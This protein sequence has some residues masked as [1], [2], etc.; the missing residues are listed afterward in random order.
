MNKK[1][2][3][4]L[5]S[6]AMTLS[7]AG[8][9]PAGAAASQ[10]T[11]AVK[12]AP[13]LKE[14]YEAEDAEL[15]GVKTGDTLDDF[16][17]SGYAAN[18]GAG[19]SVAFTV[20][21]PVAAKYGVK[22]RYSNGTGETQMVNL[23]VNG[24]KLRT[25]SLAA[26]IN[27]NTWAYR[28]EDVELKAGENTLTYQ[29]D[30]DNTGGVS[31]D[32]I[33]LSWL[34]EAEDAEQLGGMGNNDDH[35]GFTGTGFAAGYNDNGQGRR[36]KV[37][38][39]AAGEYALVM[40][41][42]AGQEN[43]EC[44][45]VSLVINGQKTQVK[46]NSLRSWKIWWDHVST[47]NLNQG[48]NTIEIVRQDGDNGQ[49]NLDY[50][51]VKPVQWTYAGKVEK[52]TG[53]NTSQLTF[54]LDNAAMQVTSVAKNVVK[55]W[56]EPDSRFSRKYES[57][58][59]QSD[60]LDPQ[61]LKA[62]DKNSYYEIDLGDMVMRVQKDPC[63]IT[64]L[65][66]KGNVLME[67]ENESMG[68]TTDGELMVNNKMQDNEAFW[69]LGEKPENNFNR[70]G[71][72]VYMWSVD[73]WGAELDDSF[74]SW[75]EGRYYMATPY[76][77]S[78]K[79][80]SILFDNSS[81]TVFDMGKTDPSTVSFG[82]VNPN[83]GGELCYYF[84]YGGT[85]D[86]YQKQIVKTYTDLIGKSFFAPLWST[87]NIQCH[88]GYTQSDVE[89]VAQTYRDEQIPLDA[90]MVDI[91]WYKYLCTPTAWNNSN[92]PNPE[93][94]LQKMKELNLHF[95][96]IDDPNITKQD[97]NADFVAGDQNGYFVKD[98]TGQ[99]KLINWP[100]GGASGLLDFFNPDARDWWGELHN[101]IL[102][103]G[104][105]FFWLDMNEP[106][107]YNADWLF[108]NEDGKSYG[109]MSEVKNAL[110]LFHHM[111]LYE[112]VTEN[113]QRTLM[114]ARTAYPG[115][116]Q[117][118]SPWTGDIQGSWTSMHQ[119][120]NNGIS[121]SASGYNYWGFDISGFFS[122]VTDEQYKR[123]IELA[124]FTPIHRIHYMTGGP[125]EAYT[126]NATEVS[127]KYIG[128][129]YSLM[130]Y[131]YSLTADNIIGIGIEE[132][133]GT[134]GTGVPITR[135]VATNYPFDENTWNLDTQFMS[136]NSFLVAPMLES[137]TQREVYLP[138]G[139]WYDYDDGKTIY[140]GGQSMSYNAP[141]DLLPVF[142]KEGSIIPMQPVMQYV[143]EKPVDEITLDVFPTLSDGDFHFVLYEDDGETMDYKTGEYTT[144]RYDANVKYT[145]DKRTVTLNIG[146]RTGSY[147]DIDER[148]YMVQLHDGYV[149]NASVTLDGKA[150]SVRSSKE[151]LDGADDGYYMD[152]A[153]RVC[154]VKVKD[155]AKAAS[156]VIS[157]QPIS[158]DTYEAEDGA[159]FGGAKVE[160]TVAGFTGSGYVTGLEADGDG[161]TVGSLLAGQTGRYDLTIRYAN[162]GSRDLTAHVSAN[163]G[164]T[165]QVSFPPTGSDWGEVVVSLHLNAGKNDVTVEVMGRDSGGML[166]DS[167]E[168]GAFPTWLDDMEKTVSQAE[169]GKLTGSAQ[170]ASSADGFT[171][172]GYVQNLTAKGD[173]VVF[174]HVNAPM[175]G[176]YTVYLRYAATDGH[177][178]KTV[179]VYVGDDASKAVQVT[180]P[181]FHNNSW[182]NEFGVTLPLAAG[183]NTVT[184]T[185]GD[186]DSGDILLDSISFKNQPRT[187]T[188]IDI[189]NGGFED[190]DL[191][192][193]TYDNGGAA[194]GGGVDGYDAVR[195]GH[196]FYFFYG[197]GP[198]NQRIGQTVTGLEN[199]TYRLE[200]WSKHYETPFTSLQVEL[201]GY[202]GDEATNLAIP[203]NG[204]WTKYSV[205]CVV[206][207]RQ[208]TFTFHGDSPK[209]S[210]MQLDEV[211]LFKVEEQAISKA[212]LQ[213]LADTA[214]A[215]Q[216][217]DYTA[218]SWQMLA[219]HKANAAQ[220]LAESTPDAQ[221][222]SEGLWRLHYAMTRLE[223]KGGEI[224]D[225]VPGDMDGNGEV[226]IQDVMEACKVLA[227]QSAGKA[228]TEEEML[229]GDLD[230]DD[231]FT[232]TD[233]MEICKI[234][235]R[236]A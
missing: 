203:Y 39:P 142:V 107:K 212:D 44:R 57:F 189:P 111:G 185:V 13:I 216:Q 215:L 89:T 48:E 214:D 197:A 202:N 82:S 94:M 193:W 179:H 234:L 58:S 40:R 225:V 109:N 95:G 158:R 153:K 8:V 213:R 20:E 74:P 187:V 49:F 209:G 72:K 131:T 211:H 183:D 192:G 69:G 76:Y 23:Y 191:T 133:L 87:G 122:D 177:A 92:F 93:A 24:Q 160:S 218:E 30:G 143:G 174:E 75:E 46:L 84:I 208:L 11:D 190:G 168:P 124:S 148:D 16:Y 204:K 126:H 106:A 52:V 171:G 136:G 102:D 108:W 110:A 77:V 37:N 123:W 173:S 21:A 188:E 145:G 125:K 210:S 47:V 6:A 98:Q 137:G 91:E 222:L 59:V 33:A 10:K 64:Y 140:T 32:R 236:K 7:A 85:E 83:P 230:G 170:R 200:F 138:A 228:P 227:R 161:V 199:G 231:K 196:K 15:T 205:E 51:T 36:F 163:A 182:W 120:I 135:S 114:L 70:R 172:S 86:N 233:V 181:G 201:T 66:K 118:V 104:I 229:R 68:W 165:Q 53:D 22:L 61:T 235:A 132:G 3:S 28:T 1:W 232:I 14:L 207:D 184:V 194:G 81:R 117:Y 42:A 176:E 29:V 73:A 141:E 151:A 9:L 130:P 90:M 88:Y 97:N 65:D 152:S 139:H 162:T 26:G 55:V 115:S 56:L 223:Q 19:Q 31:I 5:L 12:A 4:V 154:Y 195:G 164:E 67:N 198:N 63:K 45:T 38:A 134:G 41:Y 34:Y 146:A 219:M 50:I 80:Y 54:Q 17:G 62:V 157:G 35:A 112:K 2:L 144:T 71:E 43:S 119:Q 178:E 18:L 175:A 128:L 25:V 127:Q 113:G 220:V 169:D 101:M 27:E 103:Q 155:T 224:P 226:T 186:G 60:E 79:G 116:Q 96:V 167:L 105:D 180:L 159:L 121:M 99:T 156:I 100:W 129:R 166:I 150:L 147:T 221:S 78:S 206:R 217:D 149:E